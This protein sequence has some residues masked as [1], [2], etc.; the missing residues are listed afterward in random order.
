MRPLNTMPGPLHTTHMYWS[1]S[2]AV[3]SDVSV[4]RVAAVTQHGAVVARAKKRGVVAERHALREPLY[5]AK[6]AKS[7][8]FCHYI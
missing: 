6:L 5:Q 2:T 7:G 8:Y 4:V 1:L 3:A